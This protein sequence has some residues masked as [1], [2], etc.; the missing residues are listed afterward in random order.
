MS[1]SQGEGPFPFQKEKEDNAGN[2]PALSK[3]ETVKRFSP[4]THPDA[5]QSL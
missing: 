5:K 3:S 2:A 1:L 4:L